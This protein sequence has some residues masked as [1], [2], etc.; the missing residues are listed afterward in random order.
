MTARRDVV[1]YFISQTPIPLTRQCQLVH[2]RR[3]RGVVRRVARVNVA[4]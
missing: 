1:P 3:C 2:R 4:R